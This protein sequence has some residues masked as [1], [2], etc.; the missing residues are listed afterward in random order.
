MEMNIIIQLIILY[1]GHSGSIGI[2]VKPGHLPF[3][4]Y[5]AL[6]IHQCLSRLSA[7]KPSATVDGERT[8]TLMKMRRAIFPKRA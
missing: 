8:C 7:D 6:A 1:F 5:A 4:C 2:G 3:V